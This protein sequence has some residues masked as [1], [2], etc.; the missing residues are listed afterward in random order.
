LWSI[1]SGAKLVFA[2][3]EGH[4]DALYLKSIIEKHSITTI[5][6]VPSM[7]NVFL[8][9]VAKGDCNSLQRVLC[10]GESLT[11]EQVRL[12][13]NVFPQQRL[14]NLYGPTEA[15]VHISS[16]NVPENISSLVN[17]PIGSPVANTNLYVLDTNNCFVP[18][19]VVGELCIGGNQVA[20]GY[21][22]NEELTKEKFVKSPFKEG[23]RLYKTGDLAR[24][25]PDGT[26]EFMGRNDTQVK[27][28]GYRIELGEIEA[29]LS[30]MSGV[31]QCC[32]LA[33]ENKHGNN[34]LMAYVVLEGD[35]DKKYLQSQ[36][37]QLLPEY[38]VPQLWIQLTEM[39]LTANGKLNKKALPVIDNSVLATNEYTAPK[40]ILE[41]QLVSI[42]QDVL[43][44]EKIGIH[45]NFFEL[46]G[47]SLLT[48]RLISQINKLITTNVKFALL[49]EYPTIYQFAE[50]IHLGNS[51]KNDQIMIPLQ[52]LGN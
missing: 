37:K 29:T 41:S 38:M 32:V 8:E 4:K 31:K 5:H 27:I 33:K 34:H 43:G 10:S 25:Q 21:L 6:F 42:W 13:K 40:T 49:F 48:V 23:E 9:E 7:L 14:D 35:L 36:L 24:W 39:P 46:G 45:D 26:I 22:N 30:L 1:T 50:K 15:A 19:G 12:F 47:N 3:P 11:L 16:W 28:R 18:K 20:I 44:I 52:E 17:I 2:K 51:F